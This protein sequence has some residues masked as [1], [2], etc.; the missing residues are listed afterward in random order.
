MEIQLQELLDRIKRE[1]VEAARLEA[2]RILED[3]ESRRKALIA[4]AE[5]EG[6]AIVDKARSDAARSEEAGRAALAQASR[7]LLLAFRDQLQ[8]LLDA[9]VAADVR[10]AYG[11]AVLADA[12]PPVLKGLA[13]GGAEELAVL[14]PP[15]EISKLEA[16]FLSRLAK[17]LK[18]GVELRPSPDLTAGFRVSEKGG[19]AYYDFS[20]EAVAELLSRHLNSRL[21]DILRKAATSAGGH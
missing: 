20:A 19:A 2:Q 21:A 8:A 7:D 5:R 4:E 17:E 12:I 18:K 11:P 10:A 1:G 16:G 6:S 14:L 9:L 13:A 3:A 15:A